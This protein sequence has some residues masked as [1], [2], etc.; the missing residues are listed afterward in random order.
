MGS[1]V[2]Y[3]HSYELCTFPLIRKLRIFHLAAARCKL[4]S[5]EL[6]LLGTRTYFELLG[7]SE[8]IVVFSDMS[9]M[10]RMKTSW[11]RAVVLRSAG[12][13]FNCTRLT[14]GHCLLYRRELSESQALSRRIYVTFFRVFPVSRY[15][16]H[17][18]AWRDSVASHI[19]GISMISDDV[20]RGWGG[21]TF[22][23]HTCRL[24]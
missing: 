11:R 22:S 6:A 18:H 16:P 4:L 5:G 1:V 3:F 19:K 17:P 20:C 24:E 7:K 13:H 12:S 21:Q 2:R 10:L 15:Q 9:V 14:S 23:K 8:A